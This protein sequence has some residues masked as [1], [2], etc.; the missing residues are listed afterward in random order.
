M[1]TA[2]QI[3]YYHIPWVLTHGYRRY[4]ATRLANAFPPKKNKSDSGNPKS[5]S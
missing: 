2:F 5:D 3:A 4:I 1:P